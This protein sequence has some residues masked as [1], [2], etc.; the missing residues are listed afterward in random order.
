MISKV[1]EKIRIGN[2]LP[3]TFFHIKKID[4]DYRL[5]LYLLN[6]IALG[7]KTEEFLNVNFF[8]N[9]LLTKY[10]HTTVISYKAF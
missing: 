5:W 9:I 6:F 8:L 1:M 7:I 10:Y 4:F 3:K 2:L